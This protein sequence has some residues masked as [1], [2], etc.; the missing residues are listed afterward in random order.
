MA[1]GPF[2]TDPGFHVNV[3]LGVPDLPGPN[4]FD[5]S[6]RALFTRGFM[7]SATGVRL[8]LKFNFNQ[9]IR[10]AGWSESY[11]MGFATL[12]VAI[13]SLNSI[14]AFIRDRCNLLGIGPYCVSAVLSAYTQPVPL[15][16]PPVRR[17][18]LAIPVPAIPGP[19]LAYNPAFVFNPNGTFLADFAPT[20]LY[21]T[22]QTSLSGVPV[23]RRNLWLAALP[24]GSDQT[25]SGVVTEANTLAALTKFMSDLN[26]SGTTLGAGCSIAIRSIDRSGANPLKS[27]TAWNPIPNTY[28]VPGHGFLVKQP[29]VAEGMKTV[30]GGTCPKGRYLVG[31]VPD[32]DTI[33]LL[34]AKPPTAP[35]KLGAFRAAIVTFNGVSV[36]NPLGFTKRDKGR[37]SGLSVGRQPR[38]TTVRA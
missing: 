30:L 17:S 15:N 13:A 3:P 25:N 33:T 1:Y 16:A 24:D 12:A 2:D 29:I 4:I 14:N 37:P 36:A 19:G 11:D 8:T 35:L 7:A 20:V 38:K 6:A 23:Y 28:T 18:T 10:G 27:C 32:A 21:V 34:G 31:T 5:P 9:L 22:L 26:G